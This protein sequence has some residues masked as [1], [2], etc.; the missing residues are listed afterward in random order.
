M[1]AL[2]EFKKEAAKNFLNSVLL[3]DDNIDNTINE[4][5]RIDK[6]PTDEFCFSEEKTEPSR[7]APQ[8]SVLN[9]QE[10]ILSFAQKA[11]HCTPYCFKGEN[12]PVDLAVKSDVIILDW[13]LNGQTAE[14]IL[15]KIFEN[16]FHK[17]R[18]FIIYTTLCTQAISDMEKIKINNFDCSHESGSQIFDYC[19]SGSEVVS[20]RVEILDKNKISLTDLPDSLINSFSEFNN[21]FMNSIILSIISSLRNNTDSLLNIYHKNLDEAFLTHYLNLVFNDGTIIH[22]S[23]NL[24]NYI[25]ELISSDIKDIMALSFI[26][27][28]FD[29]YLIDLLKEYKHI[30]FKDTKYNIRN[31]KN[32][33]TILR[34]EKEEFPSKL[35]LNLDEEVSKE[36]LESPL[37]RLTEDNINNKEL[38]FL[39]CTKKCFNNTSEYQLKYGTIV[40]DKN[41]TYY[42]CI[43]PLCDCER[44]KKKTPFTFLRLSKNV[45]VFNWVIKDEGKFVS[46]RMPQKVTEYFYYK[47]FQPNKKTAKIQSSNKIFK[48]TDNE[49]FCW[50]CELKDTYTHAVMHHITTKYSRVGMDQFE[51]L[52]KKSN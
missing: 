10:L 18:Y 8:I 47:N 38:S 6:D 28:N 17:Y 24:L 27:N 32:I 51:W 12:F 44:I 52:R 48:A 14:N 4:N 34:E 42:L 40:K 49:E 15:K 45:N 37:I 13:L 5:V 29:E 50:I 21:S 1:T 11:I 22:A 3:I 2:D 19:V 43:Q 25:Q 26:Q 30:Y 16:S 41:Q 39:D 20:C 31:E 9:S 35:I 33:G 23:R 7:A 46:L 36:D